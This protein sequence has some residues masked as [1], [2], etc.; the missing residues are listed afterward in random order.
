LPQYQRKSNGMPP[1]VPASFYAQWR[2][3]CGVAPVLHEDRESPPERLLQS[4]W[5][6]QRLRR[7]QLQTLDGQPL[8]V[9]HP[10]FR[11]VEGGPDFRNAIVQVGGDPPLSG[12]VEVDIRSSG[13]H[14][15]GH[16]R[17]PAFQNVVLHVVWDCDR[18]AAGTPTVLLLRPALDAP[19]GELSLW[20]GGEAAQSWPEELRGNCCAPLRQIPAERLKDLLHQAAE[21]R[22]HSKAA[23]FQA[24]AR[25]A[26]WEQALWEGLFR[27]LGYKHNSWAMQRLAELRPRWHTPRTQPLALQARLFGI[28]GL[29]PVEL[30]RAQTGADSYVR[31]VW[32]QWW[33]ERDEYLDCLLPK[34][35]WCF[36]GL[37]PINHPQRRL[38]LAARWS[39]A[40]D[41]A[42]KLE[43]WCACEV[44]DD[45]LPDSLLERLQV[46]PDDYWSWHC[47]FHSRRF[48][49]L[50][51]LLGATR[52]TDLAVNVVLPWLWARAVEGKSADLQRTLEHRYFTWPRAEDN[53]VLRLA[54]Q[55]LLGGAPPRALTG[56][57]AQQ[58]LIQMVRDFCDH[59]N[60]MCERCQ[61]PTLVQVHARGELNSEA[62]RDR[63]AAGRAGS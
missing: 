46:E 32:D 42:S 59:S 52:V 55:R 62:G 33:R 37:R 45:A 36:H 14:A 40:D 5:Q 15:H 57:A 48:A 24:R 35:L 51:P 19:I 41:L 31:G 1:P 2:V 50:Q 56:A 54:R 23:Q 58:G 8:R 61:L 13:W 63:G 39:V 11:S 30:T 26:G 49:R 7:D 10:G 38:A 53:A 16:D 9:L 25:Q 27:A 60:A 44:S 20:L 34:T 47:T 21:V 28:S 4:I 17:N 12:D 43:Q 6:H 22:L 29:L 3:R 18:P